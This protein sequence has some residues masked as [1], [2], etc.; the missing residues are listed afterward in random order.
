MLIDARFYLTGSHSVK[1]AIEFDSAASA[2]H[3]SMT[4]L[5]YRI[6]HFLHLEMIFINFSETSFSAIVRIIVF[7][8]FFYDAYLQQ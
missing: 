3:C 4:R 6:H 1:R 5:N 8:S 2:L 7:K